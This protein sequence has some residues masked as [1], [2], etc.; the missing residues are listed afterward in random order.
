MKIPGTLAAIAFAMLA[1]GAGAAAEDPKPRPEEVKKAPGKKSL[2][3]SEVLVEGRVQRPSVILVTP[4]PKGM[5]DEYGRPESFLPKV[6][7][8]VKKDPF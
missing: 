5:V 8:A 1:F 7:E 2:V 6:M 4:T 3:G